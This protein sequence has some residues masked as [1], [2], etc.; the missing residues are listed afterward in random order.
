MQTEGEWACY[1][2]VE[3]VQ[4]TRY[5]ETS[6]RGD[7][8]RQAEDNIQSG[9]LRASVYTPA[10]SVIRFALIFPH[11]CAVLEFGARHDLDLD[12][13]QSLPQEP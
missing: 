2:P 3:T 7:H 13:R 5:T 1:L 11:V 4:V 12:R 6:E 10:V 8:R 9:V